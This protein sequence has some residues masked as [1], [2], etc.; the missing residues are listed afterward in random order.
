MQ[1]FQIFNFLLKLFVLLIVFFV[2]Y[3]SC[4]INQGVQI[5]GE[6]MWYWPAVPATYPVTLWQNGEG[7]INKVESRDGGKRDR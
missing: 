1:D 5:R 4:V 7:W 2:V 3:I 6:C